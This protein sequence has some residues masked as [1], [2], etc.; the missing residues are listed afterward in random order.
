[1]YYKNEINQL[2]EKA[3]KKSIVTYLMSLQSLISRLEDKGIEDDELNRKFSQFVN[4]YEIYME[5]ET[6]QKRSTAMAYSSIVQYVEKEYKLQQR[7]SIQGM[8]MAVFI[9]VGV[10]LGSALMTTVGIAFIGV[11]IAIGTGL[12][13]AIGASMEKKAKDEGRL[14]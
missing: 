14:Y 11:G 3:N 1:M 10:A 7:G 12:G 6:N 5:G 4:A 2:L 13:V 8:Y 9:G